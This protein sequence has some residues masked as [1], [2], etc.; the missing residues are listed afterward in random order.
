MIEKKTSTCSQSGDKMTVEMKHEKFR[1][2]VLSDRFFQT[3]SSLSA[4]FSW[5]KDQQSRVVSINAKLS[6]EN[7]LALFFR[8]VPNHEYR[9]IPSI[10]RGDFYKH[11]D[12][13]FN[14]C[15]IRTPSDF[16]QDNTTFEK[17]VR[18][19]HYGIPTRLLDLTSNPLVA[20]FFACY[21]RNNENS[22]VNGKVCVFYVSRKAIKYPDSDTIS[23]VANLARCSDS[24]TDTSSGIYDLCQY[25]LSGKSG[26]PDS[27]GETLAAYEKA[28]KSFNS[29]PSI[30]RLISFVRKE[31]PTFE[32][33]ILRE[34]LESV[35]AVKPLLSNA[36]IARQDGLFL[37]F[38]VN[39][40]KENEARIP[41]VDF[42]D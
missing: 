11:E 8:G 36:R 20:L 40:H 28:M 7:Q 18:M 22:G 10:N 26:L 14:E 17:L 27:G 5:L 25:Y 15:L 24:E 3:V 30:L 12:S 35:W 31:K 38:G 34:T 23:V 13:I 19:Q 39:G 41:T 1:Q 37:I 4:F 9:N 32:P 42:A 33:R 29:S 6:E 2:E 16:A 21:S